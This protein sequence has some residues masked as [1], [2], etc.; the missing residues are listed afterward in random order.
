MFSLRS[1]QNINDITAGI[2]SGRHFS[3]TTTSS[4]IP[5]PIDALPPPLPSSSKDRGLSRQ[6]CKSMFFS[7]TQTSIGF[8]AITK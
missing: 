8:A 3:P 1:L 6:S 2:K 7:Q 4:V 5:A